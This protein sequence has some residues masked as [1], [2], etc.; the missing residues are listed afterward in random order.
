MTEDA[1]DE[2]KD[3]MQE[4]DPRFYAAKGKRWKNAAPIDFTTWNLFDTDDFMEFVNGLLKEGLKFATENYEC[5]AWFIADFAD[6]EPV[7]D[8][9]TIAVQLPLGAG[10][11]EG[12]TWTFSLT[13]LVDYIIEYRERGDGGPLEED[14][15]P[16]V[17]LMRDAL[18][19]LAD[20][21]DEAL[22]RKAP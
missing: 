7:D 11:G 3:D 6:G 22:N 1:D 15:K 17:V 20:R 2:Y 4:S 5:E 21:L 14:S 13:E 18:R 12:P 10:E 8:P 19:M 9:T 16:T